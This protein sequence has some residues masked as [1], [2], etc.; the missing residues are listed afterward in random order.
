MK[1]IFILVLLSFCFINLGFAQRSGVIDPEL[2]DLMNSRSND[3]ISVN[4]VLKKQIDADALNVRKSFSSK[5]AKRKYMVEEMKYQAEKDQAD[6]LKTLQAS[7]RSSQVTDI[8]S[9][10][11][12]NMINCNATA[13]AIL[14]IAEH[15]DVESIIYNKLEKLIPDTKAKP[16]SAVRGNTQNI[17]QIQAD[18]V[19]GLGFTCKDVIVAVIDSGVNTDH[20]DLK[21]HLWS[22]SQ[23]R[24]GKNTL[25]NNYD[26]T[27]NDGHGTHCAGTICGDGTSG[28]TTGM[29]PDATLMCIKAL[30][31][32]YSDPSGPQTV[33]TVDATISAVEYAVEN[34]ADILSMSLG[35][36][37]P[38]PGVN[39]IMRELFSNTLTAGVVASVAA[40]NDGRS[41]VLAQYPVPRNI[42]APGN[43]P[44]PYLSPDQEEI[45]I[46][47]TT[48]VICIGAVNYSDE[49]CDFSSQG[50]VSWE[51]TIYADYPYGTA[52]PTTTLRYDNGNVSSYYTFTNTF[53]VKFPTAMLT[54]FG[55]GGNLSAV[56]IFDVA[57]T[58]GTFKIL[59]GGNDPSKGKQVHSQ[60]FTLSASGD[61]IDIALNKT[62]TVNTAK[63]LW[64]VFE[65]GTNVV[66]IASN[67]DDAN[68]R[69]VYVNKKWTN[70]NIPE[71]LAVRAKVT[72]SNTAE[73]H[74]GLIRP[75]V[76]APGYQIVSAS[77][78][79]NTGYA[80]MNGTSMATPCAAG[81]MA[82]LLDANP[83]LT[84]AQICKA[85]ET[86]AVKLSETKSNKTGTGRINIYDAVLSV[87]GNIPL[88]APTLT[89][90]AAST[91][92]IN[93]SWTTAPGATSYTVYRGGAQIASVTTTSYSDTGLDPGKEYCYTVKAIKGSESATSTQVC[94]TTLA[95]SSGQQYRIRVSTTSHEKYGKY[96]YVNSYTL[97]SDNT[98][99]LLVGNYAESNTQIF[100]LEDAGNGKYYLRTAD[101]YYVKCGDNNINS[102]R[103]WNTYAYST[104][105]AKTP[106]TLQYVDDVNFYIRDYDKTTGANHTVSMPNNNYFKVETGKIYC[107]AASTNTDVVTWVFELVGTTP[108][109]DPT[110]TAPSAPTNL[111][112]TAQSTSAIK[113][114]W[115]AVDGA[116]S[117][118]VYRGGSYL[119]SVATGTTY[120]DTG[121]TPNTQYC[122]KVT[123]VNTAGESAESNQSC[124]T[125][126]SES[127]GGG[128][129]D[130][131]VQIGYPLVGYY[132]RLPIYTYNF[133]SYSQQIYTED[134]VD[135]NG[136]AAGGVITKIAFKQ[137]NAV[138][139][140]RKLTV[141]MQNTSK[142]SFT[143]GKD[144]VAMTDADKVFEGEVTLKG[145]G[146]DLEITL[147]NPLTYTG[148]N[149]L[150]CVR[151]NSAS[152]T[153]M[154]NFYAYEV[155]DRSLRASNDNNSYDPGSMSSITGTRSGVNN[156][157]D[158]TF[159][160]GSGSTP[161]PD[162]T[163]TAPSAPTNLT[164]TAQ[165]TSAIKLT[166][167][168]V[169]GA[170]SYNVYRGG[171]KI[172]T[173]A[174]GTTY[175]DTGLTPNTQYCY[176]VTAVNTA[177]ESAESNQSCATTQAENTGGGGEGVV[178]IGDPTNNS[179][180][181]PIHAYYEYSYSQ[182][183]YTQAE[184]DPDGSLAGS[185]ITKIA[186][187][188]SNSYAME[189]SVVVY[190][191]NTNTSSF[192]TNS[193]WINVTDASK[194]FEGTITT[195]G[196]NQYL[197]IRLDTPLEYT[198]GNLLISVFDNT[199]KW[200]SAYPRFYCYATDSRSLQVH[201]TKQ[202]F[203][204]KNM[205]GSGND[206]S[207]NNT[208][209][210]TFEAAETIIPV[211]QNVKAIPANIFVD[212]STTISWD[213]CAGASSYN[214]YVDGVNRGSSN[215]TSYVLSNLQY[216]MN[217][218]AKVTVTAIVDGEESE[219]SKEV[220]VKV[221]GYFPLVINVVD[222]LGNPMQGV[223]IDLD[224]YDEIGNAISQTY[225]SDANGSVS[226]AKM[227]LPLLN[228]CYNLEAVKS[229]YTG[230]ATICD[231]DNAYGDIIKDVEHVVTIVMELPSPMTLY[232]DKDTYAVGENI[233]LTWDKVTSASPQGYNLYEK[234]WD[235]G[236]SSFVYEKINANLIPANTNTYTVVGGLPTR[237][238]D[239]TICLTAVYTESETSK[240]NPSVTVAKTGTGTM[241][242]IVVDENGNPIS[243]VSVTVQGTS[244]D[245][246]GSY[247]YTYT[248][249]ANGKFGENMPMGI[250]N[251]FATK[252]GSIYNDRSVFDIEIVHGEETEVI[253][254]MWEKGDEYEI[255]REIG[256][257][258][259][260][261]IDYSGPVLPVSTGFLYSASQQ[262][263]L[264]EELNFASASDVKITSVSFRVYGN[265]NAGK[266]D[267]IRIFVQNTTKAEFATLKDWTQ[268]YDDDPGFTGT[269]TMPSDGEWV[270]FNFAK[271]LEYTGG[272][273]LVAAHRHA[274][275]LQQSGF[276]VCETETR[277]SLCGADDYFNPVN[278][279]TDATALYKIN[280]I[281]ITYT[282]TSPEVVVN[283]NPI[284]FG[285]VIVGDYWTEKADAIVPVQVKGYNTK[286]DA[287]TV[288]NPFFTMPALN[289]PQNI[290]NFDM[291][292][293]RNNAPGYKA[294]VL[295]ATPQKGLVKEVKV[296]AT[297]YDPVEPDVFEKSREVVWVNDEYEDTP[298]FATLHDD[299]I[300]PGETPEAEKAGVGTRDDAVYK[301]TLERDAYVT[302][303]VYN[304]S[305]ALLSFYKDDFA[306]DA[307]DKDGPSSDN[308]F[309]GTSGAP[310]VETVDIC[311]LG[312]GT[313]GYE[314]YTGGTL[315]DWTFYNADGQYPDKGWRLDHA[316]GW[317]GSSNAN[318][319][320]WALVSETYY[321][322]HHL[323]P[324][325]YVYTTAKYE[326]TALSEMTF[327]H[328]YSDRDHWQ[329][330]FDVVIS[331][332]GV[333]FESVHHIEYT[334][335]KDGDQWFLNETVSLTAYKGRKVHIGFMHKDK[336]GDAYKDAVGGVKIDD[337]CIN[338]VLEVG[339][340][341]SNNPS[342]RASGQVTAIMENMLFP[343]GTYYAVPAAETEFTFYLT[344]QD[345]DEGIIFIGIGDWKTASNWNI[346]SVPVAT[347]DV[348]IRG[349][350]HVNDGV[351]INSIF[352][353]SVGTLTVEP[354]GTLDVIG[355][356]E[357]N[358]HSA[359]I[360]EDGGQVYQN[361]ANVAATF[362]MNINKPATW[363]PNGSNH[364]NG[365]QFIA[366]P[367]VNADMLNYVRPDE[368]D[369]DLYKYDG[370]QELEWVNY[371]LH[372]DE[373]SHDFAGSMQGWTSLDANNDGYSWTYNGGA[374]NDGAAGYL[375]CVFRQ[376]KSNDYLV[377]P[378]II[379]TYPES[380]LRFWVKNASNFTTT[381]EVEV[382]LSADKAVA[383]TTADEFVTKVGT[384]T[385]T[386]EW[387][388]VEFLLEAYADTVDRDF[389]E[390]WI[391]IRS[392]ADGSGNTEVLV[393]KLELANY[394]QANPYETEFVLGR[395]YM[396]S[397]EKVTSA[398]L[399][400]I[401]NHERSFNYDVTFNAD[402]RWEN[403]YLI[404][405]PFPFNIKWTD[406]T[407]SNIV[408]GFAVVD[409]DGS[410]VYDVNADIKVGDGIMIMTTG[411]NPSVSVS[412]GTRNKVADYLN[413]VASGSEG[414]DNFIISLS[415]D[416]YDGFKKLENF[417]DEISQVYVAEYGTHYGI[418]NR[419]EDVEEVEFCFDVKK[420][421]SYT[422][423]VQPSCE[424]STIVLYDRVEEV[425]TDM[426]ADKAYKFLARNAENNFN[427]FVLKFAKKSDV[428]DNF[429]Y[430][431]GDELVIDADGIVQI[432]DVMG[433]IIYSGEQSGI[434]R[435]N[436]RAI[437]NS[438]CVVRNINNNEVRTQK[439]VIL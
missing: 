56:T 324:E 126:Q 76:V 133:Y 370:T 261:Y 305:N 20:V 333:N 297:A 385:V 215:S 134:E 248:T 279:Q 158:I 117:Y 139:A 199:G 371:K 127:S 47:G 414:D 376:G 19:W 187:K 431:S 145:T 7:E 310:T 287:V 189:R 327:S 55:T 359:F 8:N 120:S 238:C 80:T 302:A 344:K 339:D 313:G 416:E 406:F 402:D 60:T 62:L 265:T 255:E 148:G 340:S 288:D 25:D 49:A 243:G 360:I 368:G 420:M 301:F 116:A 132:G 131:V 436:V 386:N 408:N 373:F 268:V 34:G 284:D 163:P 213:A 412:K 203:D 94:A 14:K 159:E 392:I 306:N 258:P 48:S 181:L 380:K 65:L 82:L 201:S 415:G 283:P 354:T 110:P 311:I 196:Q 335:Q 304:G 186:F 15:P 337:V 430:Q 413:V 69:W 28:T 349:D 393:D 96:L 432:G 352:I 276:Y 410:Y 338:N 128:G 102:G 44:P 236:S 374:G 86:T 235:D 329:D 391:A 350:A 357:N 396:A 233:I 321:N 171:T 149:L 320:D 278:K 157:I 12:T 176:K 253:I 200:T 111:T 27:D 10:W 325:N 122:Y 219:P 361:N 93:L 400:G 191:Q 429:V 347:D 345:I 112:A 153:S 326:I 31:V 42:N 91:S 285:E 256:E 419:D 64:V 21:D 177:G 427:R 409:N 179:G 92:S 106:L 240:G 180:Q 424:F 165:S 418:V 63:D 198:G 367:F 57:Q 323:N 282:T 175:S 334:E 154:A 267:T 6:V 387:Q 277:R 300:L 115:D 101:G 299:Y 166:W 185:L 68:G 245:G 182:Q 207:L 170:A 286:V 437:K 271:P 52:I 364:A 220:V 204:P 2:Y 197:E 296:T 66:P 162:P 251:V 428:E 343:K 160:A 227:P 54:G 230:Y 72:T 439:I 3:K 314:E 143:S 293:N 50:P 129:E 43:C 404:G 382:W 369:Y 365:W 45:E 381:N 262:I 87:A 259:A 232:A 328:R 353:E 161:D 24:H 224:G 269:Y 417:N 74:Y 239:N 280:A 384:V 241:A 167:D 108:E 225:T 218:G 18:K 315:P 53:A 366:S 398:S 147:S 104:T 71:M 234:Y 260:P 229:I 202:T 103:Y 125:T 79:S 246:S 146:T 152:F 317:G 119:T 184:I 273:L 355:G 150:I 221:G 174:T 388:Q 294:G 403:F 17:T 249:G 26:I 172:T 289:L 341:R 212:Q 275:A 70:T 140:T 194:V 247:E 30:D 250:Y 95:E 375:S 358:L 257:N 216:N 435:V 272:N 155:A 397:Y 389:K 348:I 46:G 39:E 318:E 383:P 421:G 144:W 67:E 208:I 36:S 425:E 438:A 13:D 346:N 37:Y 319:K 16:T 137:S 426:L 114:T 422:I 228:N 214:I 138:T 130:Q 407:H 405:N 270:T 33:G 322:Y 5:E 169:D 141:Y 173:V 377:S 1:R 291:G 51:N 206:L 330:M 75:D 22:D 209:D 316:S 231:Y 211:P 264:K 192:I 332:D 78:A 308:A 222:H 263:Y 183:I 205:G 379:N 73:T 378:K 274:P 401:L 411:A 342:V 190:M 40:G 290:L 4:I 298:A 23:G 363:G 97:P 242:G 32:D 121:L 59:E 295:T 84:P 423:T 105:T 164:A 90:T 399:Q 254:E 362:N 266:Q 252:P 395:G 118:N 356:I 38:G 113:L 109:P 151:D 303:M 244:C 98:P 309:Y 89:A 11:L 394:A 83:N 210:I 135:P 123:A 307:V 372:H 168:A 178:S 9:H 433:R 217:P 124:A 41:S 107:D 100:T 81:A 61:M 226:V 188:Q 193:S 281:K 142:A 35:F 29:A 195:P 292:Y 336:R 237:G 312:G 390:Y 77:N 99:T 434:N 156:S 85:L 58:S 136:N 223:T 88:S 331:E 351:Y